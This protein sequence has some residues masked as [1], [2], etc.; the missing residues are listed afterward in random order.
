VDSLPIFSKE[1]AL[2]YYEKYE[3]RVSSVGLVFGFVVDNLTLQR[4]DVLFENLVLFFYIAL[5][6]ASIVVINF[7]EGGRLRGKLFESIVPWLP[8][9]IQVAFGGLFSGYVV[10]YSRSASFITGWPFLLMLGALLIGNEFFRK[11]YQQFVFQVSILFLAV[12]SF[13]I[14][15]LPVVFKTFGPGT[16][17][18]SGIIS[19]LIISI[20]IRLLYP[21]VPQEAKRRHILFPSIISIYIGMH[22]LY[23]TNII[24]PIPLALKEQGAYHSITRT[25]TVYAA[26][27]EERT[28]YSF[29][30]GPQIVHIARGSP[31]VFYSAVF[32]PTKLTTGIVHEWQY[33]D[34]VKQAW[35]T[36][37]RVSFPIV[38]GSDGGY[39]G[40]SIKNNVEEGRWRV[41][42]ETSRGQHIGRKIFHVEYVAK[43]P[44]L[45]EVEL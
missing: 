5:A 42:V 7:W 31:V 37:S 20:F 27:G 1:N 29:L 34:D 40:Y 44:V 14:F 22:I 18:A 21:V 10:F 32:A 8:L 43:L 25:G 17:V 23:F 13:A 33:F 26:R 9:V 2:Y 11:R 36:R 19:V 35:V 38:G 41:N 15:F 12:F 6:S 4:I 28:W 30:R 45:R 16:F 3:R 24:P 39:R